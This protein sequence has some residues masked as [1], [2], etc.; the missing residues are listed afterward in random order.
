MFGLHYFDRKNIYN[1]YH[2]TQN[3]AHVWAPLFHIIMRRTI[4]FL[5][6]MWL[7]KRKKFFFTYNIFLLKNVIDKKRKKNEFLFKRRPN[8]D[9][10][11]QHITYHHLN[12]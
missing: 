10:L 1:Y 7:K 12:N 3:E 4:I 5:E 8:K 6:N 9:K 2:I 11:K